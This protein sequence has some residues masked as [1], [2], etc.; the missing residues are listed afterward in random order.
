MT[1]GLV[2]ASTPVMGGG[3]TP[4]EV[5]GRNVLLGANSREIGSQHQRN[6]S[7]GANSR[8]IGSQQQKNVLLGA[9]SREALHK[10]VSSHTSIQVCM[11]LQRFS[12]SFQL[13]QKHIQE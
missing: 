8:E 5:G 1:A 12:N 10:I 2:P 13:V 7:L 3:E 6:V 11:I 9:N 4:G